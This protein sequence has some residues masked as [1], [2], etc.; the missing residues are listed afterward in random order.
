MNTQ[1]HAKRI[2]DRANEIEPEQERAE[3]LE[4]EYAKTPEVRPIVESLFVALEDAGSFL[5]RPPVDL[6][7]TSGEPDECDTDY[8]TI[9]P[10][11]VLEKI[12]EGGMGVVFVADQSEP[13]KRRVALKVIKPG[14]DSKEVVARFEAERQ[15]LALM[16]HPNIAK[17][18]DAGMTP[19]GRPYFAM[20]LINGAPITQYCD[21]RK[22]G[23]QER[24][25]LFVQ[26]CNAVQ[27]A[28][29]KGVIHRDIKPSNVLVTK[30]DGR[31]VPV[32]IDFGVAKAINQPLTERTIY[33]C[34]NQIIGTTLYMSP[35]QAELSRY[36]VDT[37]TDVYALGVLLY[38]LL[39]GTTPFDRDRLNLAGF[40]EIRRII[41]EEEPPKP[42]TRVSTLGQTATDISSRRDIEPQRLS[43]LIRG[44]LDWIVMKSLEKDRSRRYESASRFASDI[45]NYL[46]DRVVEAR[47]PSLPYKLQKFWRR[48][49]LVAT[50]TLV[51][52]CVLV[53]GVSVTLW[54]LRVR[55][56]LTDQLRDRSL[57]EVLELVV[58]GDHPSARTAI[59]QFETTYGK[60]DPGDRLGMYRNLLGLTGAETERKDALIELERLHLK[61]RDSLSNAML[62]TCY[63]MTSQEWDY[64]SVVSG[65]Y[66][67]PVDEND[68]AECL[69]RGSALTFANADAASQD[70]AAAVDLKPSSGIARI[71]HARALY[72]RSSNCMDAKHR[73]KLAT[74][75]RRE[76]MVGQ[77]ILPTGNALAQTVRVSTLAEF[78]HAEVLAGADPR[79]DLVENHVKQLIA[80][81][82]FN[83]SLDYDWTLHDAALDALWILDRHQ[84]QVPDGLREQLTE[85]ATRKEAARE[86]AASLIT[87]HY[88]TGGVRRA[89]EVA[90]KYSETLNGF[91]ALS[92]LPRCETIG[93]DEG[94]ER[95]RQAYKDQ[96]R[97]LKPRNET[98]AALHGMNHWSMMR[99]LGVDG[100][101]KEAAKFLKFVE[102]QHKEGLP[103]ARQL[104]PTVRK[105]AGQQGI[106]NDQA[107]DA[108]TD[109]HGLVHVACW[110]GI[111][112]LANNDRS[113]ARHH[114]QL[115]VDTNSQEWTHFRWAEILLHRIEDPDF[116]P[117]LNRE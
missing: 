54:Q 107:L 56:V 17:V 90:G 8:Q 27:H 109:N 36:G 1:H 73:L 60:A 114:F 85:Y 69:M 79:S 117:W 95:C 16:E 26:V 106:S 13:V 46:N 19:D 48:N 81:I 33:T 40:D 97:A 99:L 38:E 110:L 12:G 113:T 108:C 30:H 72:W 18:F 35:E 91:S 5:D 43:L 115:A 64:W 45:E 77:A 6:P 34:L 29:Q 67:A 4:R 98:H 7:S 50:F 101:E 89:A 66:S 112:A 53:S 105:M 15:A 52:A 9:G 47:R 78:V 102:L 25:T 51:L 42:S 82:E 70:L 104:L 80:E 21:A 103:L 94:I 11:R 88:K 58:Q 83:Q 59:Q 100:A 31:P 92:M 71:L 22:L 24:L 96:A 49:R 65:L 41:R 55:A 61:K 44:D 116:L 39:T 93:A 74:R 63:I 2:F 86:V 87:Y 10:F 20:E 14:M 84:F 3:F 23:I 62:A 28:H 111:D 76:A 75:A 32:V 57:D 68:F 37:R